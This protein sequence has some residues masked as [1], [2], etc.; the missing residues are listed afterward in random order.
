MVTMETTKRELK[1]NIIYCGDC[2]DVLKRIPD[3]SVDLIYSD[4]PFFSERNYENFWVK[5]GKTKLSFTDTNWKDMKD[6]LNEND[7]REL[8]NMEIRWKGGKSVGG[9]YIFISYLKARMIQCQRVLKETGSIYVHCDYHASHYIK[10]MLDE[11]FNYKNFKN[12]IIWCYKSGGSS[13]QHF[14]RKHDT[15]FFYTKSNKYVFNSVKEKSYMAEGSGDNPLQTYYNDND[16][17]GKYTLVNTK[18]WWEI[19]MLSTASKER[20]GYPT[21]KPEALLERIIKASSN[22]GDIVLDCFCGCG[23]AIAVANKLNRNFIGID[24]SRSACDV[25]KD[26]LKKNSCNTEI[27]GGLTIQEL[28]EMKPHEFAQIMIRMLNGLPNIKK[29]NDKG[30]DGTLEFGTIPVQVKQWGNNVNRPEIDKFKTAIERTHNIKGV[31]IAF[32]YSQSC[33]SEVARIKQEN[34]IEIE[35]LKVEDIIGECKKW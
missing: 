10:M 23:T 11:V 3:N 15:I 5:D 2:L 16:E 25:M 29:T 9:L 20:L 33:H 1:T 12:E 21:Q 24:I 26:R 31:M 18:D 30:I 34:N 8:E 4:S 28:K 32:D 22:E 13:K 19:G 27:I 17:K 7:Q 14:S 6:K 35:L